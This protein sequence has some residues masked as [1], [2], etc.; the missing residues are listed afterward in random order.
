MA[1]VYENNITLLSILEQL[2]DL[3]EQIIL[4]GEKKVQGFH[5]FMMLELKREKEGLISEM[6]IELTKRNL[7]SVMKEAVLA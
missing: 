3:N 4:L 7:L 5:E 1:D 6:K 2:K